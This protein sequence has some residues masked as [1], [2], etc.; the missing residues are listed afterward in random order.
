MSLQSFVL[1]IP[2]NDFELSQSLALCRPSVGCDVDCAEY[3][4]ERMVEC[5]VLYE[6]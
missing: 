5:C 6:R 3:S 2:L 4:T 1:N